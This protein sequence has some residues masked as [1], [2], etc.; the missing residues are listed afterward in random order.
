MS[1]LTAEQFKLISNVMYEPLSYIH[2]DYNVLASPEE[3]T[4][5][6]KI[7]NRHLIQQYQL[8][9]HIDCE[10]DT[11]VEKIF[12]HWRTLPRCAL[13]L[14][15]FY[16]RHTLLAQNYY[17]LEPSLKAFLALYPM[18]NRSVDSKISLSQL[19]D[20][21]PIDIGYQLLF[22]F[23]KLISNALAQRFKLLFSPKSLSINIE[24]PKSLV[25]S[26]TLF[27]LVLDY[28]TLVT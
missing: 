3:N 20:T 13:F 23:I 8:I 28:A 26:P 17:H 27:L 5:W 22:N 15:Y 7:A 21:S 10:I 16:S 4:L 2:S 9:L 11:T 19:K 6:Q 18:L 24:F 25:L 14:G 12:T 1:S